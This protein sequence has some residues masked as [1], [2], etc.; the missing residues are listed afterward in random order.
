MDSKHTPGPWYAKGSSENRAWEV[1]ERNT[2]EL[3]AEL[4]TIDATGEA[5]ARLIAAAP[6]LL[7]ALRGLVRDIEGRE[8]RT[9]ITQMGTAIDAA[10]AALAKA[11]GR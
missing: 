6:D 10:R 1:A 5:D 2:G 9:G 4:N 11:E 3:V 8:K 7:A